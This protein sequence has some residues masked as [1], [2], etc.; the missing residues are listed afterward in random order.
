MNLIERYYSGTVFKCMNQPEYYLDLQ[1]GEKYSLDYCKN[2]SV[3]AVCGIAE[4]QL[5]E[6]TLIKQ[7]LDIKTLIKFNDHHDYS[8]NDINYRTMF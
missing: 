4:P 7:G 5:F 6:E 3:I 2:K 8:I 1:T